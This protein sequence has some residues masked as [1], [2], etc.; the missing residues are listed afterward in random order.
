MFGNLLDNA[1]LYARHRVLIAA[2]AWPDGIVVQIADDGPVS[3]P[4]NESRYSAGSS[5]WTPAVS[6][7]AGEPPRAGYRP[8]YRG[9]AHRKHRARRGRGEPE[10]WS[11]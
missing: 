11:P 5:R 9:R 10:R 6:R 4:L 3:R 1:A 2:A 7:A 8:G